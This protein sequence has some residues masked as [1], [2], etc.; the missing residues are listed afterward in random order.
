MTRHYSEY[1]FADPENAK[2]YAA[3]G[4]VAFLPGFSVM[5]ELT[6]QLIA[7]TT[8]REGS[9]LVIGAG[10]GIELKA[11]AASHPSW[12]FTAVDPSAEMLAVAKEAMAGSAARVAW[13]QGYIADA[14]AGP[15]DSV[16]CLLTL[17]LISDDGEKLQALQEMKRRL[18]PGGA[19]AVVDNCFDRSLPDFA[20][21]LARFIEHARNRGVPEDVLARVAT[22]VET[23]TESVSEQRELALLEQAGF[24]D[25]ELYFAGLSWRGFI[26]RA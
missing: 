26:A 12:C 24:R 17:H 6:A 15:Y 10:G 18:K 4:P 19:F 21:K 2:R 25:I 14:P 5:H 22:D 9:V 3:A 1:G 13:V 20:R 7:E 8:P 23:K 16:T 11:F